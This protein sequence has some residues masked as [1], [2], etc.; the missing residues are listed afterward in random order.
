[1]QVSRGVARDEMMHSVLEMWLLM[2]VQTFL[3]DQGLMLPLDVDLTTV[4]TMLDVACGSGQWV[5]DMA[6]WSLI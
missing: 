2:K 5:R 6:T 3:Y 1:M 4:W